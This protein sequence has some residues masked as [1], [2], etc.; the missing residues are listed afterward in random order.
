M[1]LAELKMLTIPFTHPVNE[2]LF[3]DYLQMVNCVALFFS[4]KIAM[5]GSTRL[6]QW[7]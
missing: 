2:L 6:T 1:M 7:R 3:F 5:I 4:F